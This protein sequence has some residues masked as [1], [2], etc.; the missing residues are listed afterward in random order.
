M[1]TSVTPTLDVL[2]LPKT[3]WGKITKSVGSTTISSKAEAA[4]DGSNDV[5]FNVAVDNSDLDTAIDFDSSGGSQTI[6]VAK[7]FAGLGG[8]ISV[9]P[10]FNLQSSAADV[11]LGYDRDDTSVTIEASPSSQKLTVAQ[12]ITDNHKITP[13]ITSNGDVAVAWKKSL[14]DGNSLTT[15]LKVNDSL[16]VKWEDGPWTATISSPMDGIAIGEVKVRVHRKLSFL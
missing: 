5:S 10:S 12:Q 4:L 15:T 3:L 1:T 16:N 11:V 14:E 13:S 2:S 8:R 9:N 6:Q 7:S